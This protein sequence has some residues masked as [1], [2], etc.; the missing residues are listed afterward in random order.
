[1]PTFVTVPPPTGAKSHTSGPEL[2]LMVLVGGVVVCAEA[3]DALR[4]RDKEIDARRRSAAERKVRKRASRM[5]AS[6][7]MC[8]RSSKV[9]RVFGAGLIWCVLISCGTRG[10]ACE[11]TDNFLRAERRR[12]N[13]GIAGIRDRVKTRGPATITWRAPTRLRGFRR[14]RRLG[15]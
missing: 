11:C 7:R 13:Q 15:I 5:R 10:M 8:S 14:L 6:A 12:D 3:V 4:N 9:P 2:L 1:M